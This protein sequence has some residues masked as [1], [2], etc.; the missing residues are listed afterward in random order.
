MGRAPAPLHCGEVP[1]SMFL[2]LKNLLPFALPLAAG[3]LAALRRSDADEAAAAAAA[4][5]CTTGRFKVLVAGARW[6]ELAD[7]DLSHLASRLIVD[8][9]NKLQDRVARPAASALNS[10]QVVFVTPAASW[11]NWGRARSSNGGR[12]AASALAF[13]GWDQ[14]G[15]EWARSK[16]YSARLFV[17]EDPD[18]ANGLE[19]TP[20]WDFVFDVML[21]EC[22]A[23]AAAFKPLASA[24]RTPL[25]NAWWAADPEMN[26]E[27]V[28]LA[29]ALRDDV[30][31]VPF[32]A[33]G[34]VDKSV[35]VREVLAA[36]GTEDAALKVRQALKNMF[37]LDVLF[38]GDGFTRNAEGEVLCRELLVPTKRLSDLVDLQTIDLG[39]V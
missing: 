12:A 37:Y 27:F 17:W 32:S 5:R 26:A 28:R 33:E 30:A 20:T 24:P 31:A 18:L 39:R 19:R 6:S 3:T 2:K 11:V 35:G 34:M 10:K 29:Q 1:Q 8:T 22:E 4:P 15:I 25:P 36:T 38:A 14:E 16:D 23:G 21:P 7:L 13:V 9:E